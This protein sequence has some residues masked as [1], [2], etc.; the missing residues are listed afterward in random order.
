MKKEKD[1]IGLGF[2]LSLLGS[3]GFAQTTAMD[4]EGVGIAT[5]ICTICLLIWTLETL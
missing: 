5:A 1:R 3:S 2:A 4:F